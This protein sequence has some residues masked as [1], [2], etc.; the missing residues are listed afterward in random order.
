VSV[1]TIINWALHAGLDV[2]ILILLVLVCRR[3]FV[4]LFGARAAYALWALPITRLILPEIP[5]TLPRP[6]WMHAAPRAP[7]TWT[8]TPIIETATSTPLTAPPHWQFLFI[9]L[10][11]GGAFIWL[12]HQFW[13]QYQFSKL[14]RKNSTPA[15]GPLLAI[16]DQARKT[17]KLT[18]CPDI[19]I[20][21]T[22]IG[23]FVSGMLK[24]VIILPHN[25]DANFNQQQQYYALTHELAHIK[26][27][28]L[29]AAFGALIFRA[30]NWPNPLVHMCMAK[31]RVDQESACDAYVLNTIG[32]G[33]QSRQDYAATLVRS[34]RLTKNLPRTPTRHAAHTHPFCLTIYHPLKERL[35]TIKTSKTSMSVLSRIGVGTFLIAALTATSP[36]AIIA[37]ES[38]TPKTQTTK[39][40]KVMQWVEEVDGVKTSKHIEV[41]TDNG[42]TTVYSIDEF[43]NKTVIDPSELN[44]MEAF[45][46]KHFNDDPEDGTVIIKKIRRLEDGQMSVEIEA[47]SFDISDTGLQAASIVDAAKSLLDQADDTNLS[48]KAR[49]KLEKAR[50]ALN[51][52]KEALEAEQ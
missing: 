31:F 2:S 20:A 11:L 30:L 9:V 48:S 52:A 6:G 17:V 34:A 37:Q 24:P 16:C 4:H 12:A 41:T 10:W 36:I 42:V 49:R 45:K 39:S 23:P 50:K 19:R 44:D 51:E 3:P 35:M 47:N 14:I 40:K 22:D 18:H 38:E 21:W 8:A 43:G 13:R 46:S 28:D 15:E 7:D 32:G 29:W 5:I 1:E 33:A 27:G 26:R 25:F